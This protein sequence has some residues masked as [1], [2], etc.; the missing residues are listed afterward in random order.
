[1]TTP[2]TPAAA[3]AEDLDLEALDHLEEN[4]DEYAGEEVTP[5]HTLEISSFADDEEGDL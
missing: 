3:A 5:E 2:D 4:P 1:M